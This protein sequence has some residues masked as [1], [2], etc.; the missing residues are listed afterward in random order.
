MFGNL[1]WR[2]RVRL[3]C[4]A[5][6]LLSFISKC[7]SLLAVG[8]DCPLAF[9]GTAVMN[10]CRCPGAQSM[11]V[12]WIMNKIITAA[13]LEEA[14]TTQV[15]SPLAECAAG[16]APLCALW[17]RFIYSKGKEEGWGISSPPLTL[18]A[19]NLHG[20]INGDLL[21]NLQI[22]RK[23]G[24]SSHDSTPLLIRLWSGSPPFSHRNRE[25]GKR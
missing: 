3:F 24:N 1:S 21:S 20:L 12:W 17:F 19:P 6:L 18:I 10:F 25:L 4:W 8:T 2:Q 14:W 5:S 16:W 23:P 22:L 15:A 9:S 13:G 7:L 11:A